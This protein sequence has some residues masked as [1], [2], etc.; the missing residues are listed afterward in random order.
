MLQCFHAWF[1]ILGYTSLN[2]LHQFLYSIYHPCLWAKKKKKNRTVE[3][4]ILH[5]WMHVSSIACV[6]FVDWSGH[7]E[8][9]MDL[10]LQKVCL[11]QPLWLLLIARTWYTV[12]THTSFR[13][14]SVS[15]SYS[16]ESTSTYQYYIQY[17]FTNCNELL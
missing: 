1:F 10:C 5:K 7:H 2:C 13:C 12:H 17:T 15:V 14:G 6:Y 3:E 4:K 16:S 11:I 8:D 9:K